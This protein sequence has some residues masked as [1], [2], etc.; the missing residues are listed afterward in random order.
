M[1][2]QQ[3]RAWP[4]RRAPPAEAS[5]RRCSTSC[6]KRT[7]APCCCSRSAGTPGS[8]SI[9]SARCCP[10]RPPSWVWPTA[11]SRLSYW[12]RDRTRGPR[13]SLE[14][15]VAKMSAG[16]AQ[17]YRLSDRGTV[18][19]GMRADLN[20]ID[21]DRLALR[22]PEVVD[23]LPTN[24]TRLIQR[25]DGYVATLVGGEVISREDVDT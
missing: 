4:L 12:V 18:A 5:R 17:L 1:S 25:A 11:T 8:T 24:A 10:T 14:L 22:A 23:D 13:L 9:T 16:P 3:R 7:G 21:F 6:S 15:A 20:L 19:P 2:R